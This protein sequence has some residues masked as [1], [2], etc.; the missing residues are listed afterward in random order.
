MVGGLLIKKKRF[1]IGWP[2]NH[3]WSL[4]WQSHPSIWPEGYM[5]LWRQWFS[6]KIC[7]IMVWSLQTLGACA[8]LKVGSCATWTCFIIA[9]DHEGLAWQSH[10]SISLEGY[11]WRYWC[12]QIIFIIMVRL[13]QTLGACA[14]LKV[15]LL[16]LHWRVSSL[17]VT[18]KVWHG[19]GIHQSHQKGMFGDKYV[20]RLSL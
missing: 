8:D 20:V 3:A 6:Q 17:Q 1:I 12:G 10:P 16:L 2:W 13:S 18:M 7:I 19:K 5:Y 14:D 4:A 9:G 11:V 15:A